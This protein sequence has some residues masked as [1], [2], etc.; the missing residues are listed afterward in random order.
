MFEFKENLEKFVDFKI[1]EFTIQEKKRLLKR[2][3]LVL[4]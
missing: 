2:K 1:S 4:L 3:K